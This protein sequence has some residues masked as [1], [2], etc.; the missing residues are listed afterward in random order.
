MQYGE[1][2]NY[3]MLVRSMFNVCFAYHEQRWLTCSDFGEI[4]KQ[5]AILLGYW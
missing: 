1:I 2:T 4:L 3:W 5:R